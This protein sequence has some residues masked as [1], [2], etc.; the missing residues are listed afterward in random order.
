M[1]N[2]KTNRSEFMTL[3]EVAEYL[4][5]SIH[6]IYKMAQ[7]GRIPALKAGAVWRFNRGEIDEW[8]RSEAARRQEERRKKARSG[9]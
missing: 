6:T 5:L 4:R 9:D 7:K 2:E 1:K 3:P 8:M